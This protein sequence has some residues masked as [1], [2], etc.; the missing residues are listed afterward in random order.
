M[1]GDV[2]VGFPKSG[3]RFLKELSCNNDRDWFAAHKETY[4]QE[5]KVPAEIF[6][7]LYRAA[8]ADT[9]LAKLIVGFRK[10]GLRLSEPELKRV[11]VG[12]DAGG[13]NAD[14]LRHKSLTVWQDQKG[15]AEVVSK[16]AIEKAVAAFRL[17]KPLR[18]FFAVL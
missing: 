4:E 8:A 6:R 11:P 3:I 9:R 14:L 16:D 18:D 1:G 7:E 5:V 15:H 13:A 10:Q 2:F 12:Y 17:M